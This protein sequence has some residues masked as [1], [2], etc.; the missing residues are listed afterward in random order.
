MIVVKVSKA[1]VAIIPN[2]SAPRDVHSGGLLA[3]VLGTGRCSAGL[4]FLSRGHG[5]LR[6]LYVLFVMGSELQRP[7]L[8]DGVLQSDHITIGADCTLGTGAFVHYGVTMGD[9]AILGTDSFVMKGEHIPPRAR[10]QGNPAASMP[11]NDGGPC[12]TRP[13]GGG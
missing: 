1:C 11:G 4:R 5:F 12:T 8:E 6:R 2:N 7:S 9:G 3:G 13:R 10:W